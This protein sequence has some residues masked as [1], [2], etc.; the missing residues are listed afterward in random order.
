MTKFL[1][2]CILLFL[3]HVISYAQISIGFDKTYSFGREK[4]KDFTNEELG[5]IKSKTLVFF[6]RKS[7]E[8]TLPELEKAL[9]SVWTAT[10][11]KLV[12]FSEAESYLNQPNYFYVSITTFINGSNTPNSKKID[13][14][15][16]LLDFWINEAQEKAPKKS[17]ATIYLST[18]SGIPATMIVNGTP[19][20]PT[21]SRPFTPSYGP[22]ATKA[23]TYYPAG[24]FGGDEIIDLTYKIKA[25]KLLVKEKKIPATDQYYTYLYSDSPILNWN[26]PDL[27]AYFAVVNDYLV[28]G[29]GRTFVNEENDTNELQKLENNTLI[30]P[31]YAFLE[32][33]RPTKDTL[34][35]VQVSENER[36][37]TLS[38]YPYPYK[39][40]NED[41]L[42]KAIIDSSKTTYYLMHIVNNSKLVA[43]VNSKTGKI[44]YTKARVI[45]SGEHLREK[46]MI[47]LKETI[48]GERK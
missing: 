47:L 48:D 40:L 35:Y 23:G 13:R 19:S 6:Y 11:L 10:P 39:I 12:P 31:D 27:K 42:T 22:Y 20:N 4:I 29:K 26:I 9:T 32:L 5:K 44:I 18:G 7:D 8:S 15:Y 38:T 17:F 1:P 16:L 30:I 46:D 2:Y 24:Y 41:Q 3:L 45:T 33:I 25:N 34:E 37:K 21:Y 36:N 14:W 28:R 43:I